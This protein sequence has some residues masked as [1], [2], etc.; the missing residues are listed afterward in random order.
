[1]AQKMARS[2]PPPVAR[3][4]AYSCRF[5]RLLPCRHGVFETNTAVDLFRSRH[6]SEAGQPGLT[7][8]VT[9]V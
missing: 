1:M 2:V 7:N 9:A 4:R 5:N 6:T 3:K 8:Y